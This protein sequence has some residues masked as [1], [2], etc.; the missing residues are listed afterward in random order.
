[1]CLSIFDSNDFGFALSMGAMV[2]ALDHLPASFLKV[3]Q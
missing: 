1:M 2:K 3:K